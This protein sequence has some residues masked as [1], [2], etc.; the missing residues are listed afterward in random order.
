MWWWTDIYIHYSYEY[1]Y[2]KNVCEHISF[3]SL[4]KSAKITSVLSFIWKEVSSSRGRK[5]NVK[6]WK[7][8]RNVW[9]LK[10]RRRSRTIPGVSQTTEQLRKSISYVRRLILLT[11]GRFHSQ[12]LDLNVKLM[13]VPGLRAVLVLGSKVLDS[14]GFAYILVCKLSQQCCRDNV[15][16]SLHQIPKP[17]C[18]WAAGK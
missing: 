10:P 7:R 17:L 6:V 11:L 5:G 18:L 2:I 3:F 14:V 1:I 15:L 9:K 12:I 4:L 13:V 8:D 16:W